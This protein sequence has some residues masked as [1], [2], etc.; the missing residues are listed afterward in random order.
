MTSWRGESPPDRRRVAA[1]A[2]CRGPE[3]PSGNSSR[4]S[5]LRFLASRLRFL[6]FVLGSLLVKLQACLRDLAG[7]RAIVSWVGVACGV[8]LSEV[9][10]GNWQRVKG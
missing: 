2:Q 7:T 8:R 4:A 5:R 9:A 3:L 10:S 1:G 6:L